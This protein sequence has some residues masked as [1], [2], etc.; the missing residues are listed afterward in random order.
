MRAA[1]AVA[2]AG[3]PGSDRRTGAEREPVACGTAV[4]FGRPVR[5][6]IPAG[7]RMIALTLVLPHTG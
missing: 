2:E 7:D 1:P 6:Q 3:G 5:A 4:R